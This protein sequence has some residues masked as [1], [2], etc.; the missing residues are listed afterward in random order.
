MWSPEPTIKNGVYPKNH[1]S[2][3]IILFVMIKENSVLMQEARKSLENKWGL[4]I[5][6]FFI[7]ALISGLLS[8]IPFIGSLGSL[9]ITGPLYLGAAIFS[10]AIARD[11]EANTNQLFKG[12]DNFGNALA[13]YLLMALFVFLWLLLLIIPGI[14]AAI[15]YSMTFFIMADDPSIS[16]MDAID[17]SKK[18]MYGYKAKYFFLGFRFLG[19]ILLSILTLGIGLLWVVPY[20]NISYAKFYEDIKA[21]QD[22]PLIE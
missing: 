22:I 8:L 20:M 17:K 10:L 3:N 18:M 12:F 13:A 16:S 2:R 7:L 21:N 4:A 11:E 14:I 15:S 19:W 1:T 9:I 5:G 6:T